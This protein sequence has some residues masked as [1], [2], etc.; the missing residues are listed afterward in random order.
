MNDRVRRIVRA[1]AAVVVAGA[2]AAALTAVVS[3]VSP[4][5]ADA[6]GVMGWWNRLQQSGTPITVPAPP[7]APADGL[8]VAKDPVNELAIAAVALPGASG[9][10]ATLTIRLAEGGNGT[11]TIAACP[12]TKA[13]TP[14][15]NGA[16][17]DAPTWD[18]IAV[19]ADPLVS[20]DGR[21]LTFGLSSAYERPEGL[22]VVL[23]PVGP[24]PFSAGIE[25]PGT[26]AFT[27]GSRTGDESTTD[28][29]AAEPQPVAFDD[30]PFEA[31]AFGPA[32]GFESFAPTTPSFSPDAPPAVAAPPTTAA[33]RVNRPTP[34]VLR[35]ATTPAVA[36][37]P[38]GERVRRILAVAL[39]AAIGAAA[40]QLAKRPPPAP[41]LIG[42]LAGRGADG[43]T[44]PTSA[45]PPPRMGGIGRFAR[46]RTSLPDR[47]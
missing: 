34:R 46:P 11:P 24:A 6:P 2:S 28:T 29:T 1:A 42:G 39:L 12:A 32:T 41:R 33:P 8:F 45:T 27:V 13:V 23:V 31:D 40:H 16:W 17:A 18:C 20:T 47:L 36:T 44:P 25:K 5:D 15:A 26:D 21:T 30:L 37:T 7:G 10:G 22:S 4:A 19:R 38:A 14:A 3:P 9:A 35:P 43:A